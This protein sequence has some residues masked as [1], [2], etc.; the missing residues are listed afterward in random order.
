MG[1]RMFIAQLLGYAVLGV[2]MDYWRMHAQPGGQAGTT[3]WID[4][5]L[6]AIDGW[7]LFLSIVF[8]CAVLVHGPRLAGAAFRRLGR[9]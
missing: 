2:A 4:W 3:R 5:A 8:W 7:G 9:S 1:W 6:V